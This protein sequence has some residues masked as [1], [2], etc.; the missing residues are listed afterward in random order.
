MSARELAFG[1]PWR[2]PGGC[3]WATWSGL[4]LVVLFLLFPF[5]VHS[6]VFVV[7]SE[8]SVGRLPAFHPTNVELPQE[9]L[10]EQTRQ[11]LIRL[12]TA[13]QGFAARPF[14]RG[15]KGVTLQANDKLSPDQEKYAKMLYGK[16]LAV[17]AGERI[18][19]TRLKI[20]GKRI[21]FDLNGGPDH[22]HKWLRHVQIGMS[23]TA[24]MP[25]VK[26]DAVPSAGARITLEFR[27]YV[28]EM[29]GQQLRDL[30]APLID[31]SLKSPVQAY[32]DTLP[33]ELRDAI[34]AHHVL[35]G[36]DRRMVLASLGRP[37]RKIRETQP[38]GLLYEEWLYGKP[39]DPMQFVRLRGDRVVRMEIAAVGKDPVVRD[40]DETG[41]YFSVNPGREVSYGDAS[42]TQAGRPSQMP[43]L[44]N[45]GEAAP[46]GA[47]PPVNFPKEKPGTGNSSRK[48]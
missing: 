2:R 34:L 8:N 22:K 32:T 44:R 6:Q 15:S 7:G 46:P 26:D 42:P 48:E 36:M 5:P 3:H 1:S 20:A 17:G 23:R 41:G 9:R 31:F 35:V 14:P 10:T 33:P 21:V 19:I 18:A 12:F 27:D 13:E 37:E 47:E 43:T 40:Q 30:L 45:P 38:D 24:T 25:I 16:G 28:P 4:A 29:T 39:P 11:Q